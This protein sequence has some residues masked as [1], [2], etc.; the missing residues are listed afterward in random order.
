MLYWVLKLPV[1]TPHGSG[2]P[3]VRVMCL[4]AS[5]ARDGGNA[6]TAV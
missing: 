4:L 5:E 6:V 3:R 1:G 2:S